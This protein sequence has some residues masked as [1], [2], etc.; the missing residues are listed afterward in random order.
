MDVD[1]A[2]VPSTRRK[3]G[4]SMHRDSYDDGLAGWDRDVA[5]LTRELHST[6]DVDRHVARWDGHD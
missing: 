5:Y 4:E 3:I 2:A 1:I 6:H